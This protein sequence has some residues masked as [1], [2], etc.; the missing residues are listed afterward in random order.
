MQMA[1]TAVEFKNKGVRI[2]KIKLGKDGATDLQRVR[3]IREAVGPSLQL[4]I[5]ANQGW[6]FETA[7]EILVKYGRL[8]Y[9]IL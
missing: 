3:Q 5:D 2:I 4:R 6:D 9:R 8:R 1:E 7:K